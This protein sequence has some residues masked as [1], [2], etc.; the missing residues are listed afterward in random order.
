MLKLYPTLL[1]TVLLV[2]TILHAQENWMKESRVVNLSGKWKFSIGDDREWSKPGYDDSNWEEIKVPS[3]WED[4]GFHGY[5]GFAWYRKQ[6][7]CPAWIKGKTISIDMGYIDDADEIF[8]NG[9][10]VGATGTFPPHYSTAYS[11]HRRYIIP[12]RFLHLNGN[13]IIAV[14]VYDAELSGGILSGHQ[15]INVMSYALEPDYRIEG[16][17]KFF[18][19]DD[20]NARNP[21]YDDSRWETIM[22]PGAWEEQGYPDLDGYAWYRKTIRL[23]AD[24]INKDLVLIL[25]KIDDMDMVYL[26]GTPIGK[27]GNMDREANKYDYQKIRGYFIPKGLLKAGQNNVIAIRV[28][29]GGYIGGMYMGPVGFVTQN[30]YRNFF[31]NYRERNSRSIWDILI[32]N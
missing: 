27:T 17:W 1:L 24:L 8:I 31:R 29:D 3:A 30:R 15:R 7:F 12:E 11:A 28:F 2:N 20:F 4:Q 21:G 9:Y 19:G 5:D 32:G 6:F 26:N 13:N 14:K 23:T 16:E 25:G 10:S 18:P 22:V